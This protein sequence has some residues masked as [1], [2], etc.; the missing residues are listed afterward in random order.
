MAD[1]RN[2]SQGW[3]IQYPIGWKVQGSHPQVGINVFFPNGFATGPNREYLSIYAV[4]LEDPMSLR[5]FGNA[6]PPK[7]RGMHAIEVLSSHRTTAGGED[8]PAWEMHYTNTFHGTLWHTLRTTIM[9]PTD[10]QTARV[11][12]LTAVDQNYDEALPPAQAMTDSFMIG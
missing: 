3:S 6:L 9:L 5:E 10:P 8:Y 4:H 11:L 1:Y 2:L 7:E 12:T